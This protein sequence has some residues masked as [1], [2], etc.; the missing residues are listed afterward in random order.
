VFLCPFFDEAAYLIDHS[1]PVLGAGD[2]EGVE[3]PSVRNRTPA[4]CTQYCGVPSRAARELT[5]QRLEAEFE[6]AHLHDAADGASAD[7]R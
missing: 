1:G 3:G 7:F 2:L 6:I 5:E 4:Y